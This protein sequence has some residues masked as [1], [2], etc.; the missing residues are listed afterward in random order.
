MKRIRVSHAAERDL[1]NIWCDIA[2]RSGSGDIAD[3][4]IESIAR[5]FPVLSLNPEAGRVRNDIEQGLRSFPVDRYVIY[6]RPIGR[7]LV[8]SRVIHGMRD[9]KRAYSASPG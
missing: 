4:L 9:Q 6:Y 3:G 8:I 5:V 1:D 7:Y 2:V